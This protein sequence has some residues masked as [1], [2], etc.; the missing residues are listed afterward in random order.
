MELTEKNGIRRFERISRWHT[1]TDTIISKH[2]RMV[3][4]ADEADKGKDRLW[5]T[6]FVH[7]S[8]TFPIRRYAAISP[9]IVLSDRSVLSRQ[10]IEDDSFFIEINSDNSQVRLYKEIK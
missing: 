6:C 4:Y 3:A 7:G 8:K 10:D 5:I 9:A 2:N 1:L